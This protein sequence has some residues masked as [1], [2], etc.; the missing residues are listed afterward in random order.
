MKAEGLK[1]HELRTLAVIAAA[2]LVSHF[3]ILVLPPLFPL[4]KERLGVGFVE[5]GLALTIFN[6]VSG[7][8]QAPM[9]FIADRI[10]PRR[11][12][13]AGLCLGSLAFISL[14]MATS[15]PWLL[16]A[17]ALAGLANSVYHPCDYAI[18]SGAIGDARVGRAFS[19]HTF[20]GY[21]GGAIAPV[22]MLA[23]A[24]F[25]GVTGALIAAGV[26]G[27]I[28]AVPVA[29]S[30]GT[31]AVV[32]TPGARPAATKVGLGRIVTPTVLSLMAFFV[33]LSL[34]TGGIN[35]FSVVALTRGYD[36]SLALAN[37]AL[38]AFL[39][40]SAFGVLCGGFLADKT[41]HH[42]LVAAGGFGMTAVL[43]AIVGFVPLGAFLLL[44][45]MVGAGFLSGMIAPSRDMLV[46]AAAPPGAAGRVFG[47]VSTGFN[48]GGA[49]GPML[50][51]WIMD[52]GQPSWVFG[53]AVIF[54]TITVLMA[55]AGESS[56]RPRRFSGAA[57]AGRSSA[58]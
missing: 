10:G 41:R 51:G 34:S 43:I 8:T 50:F 42:G 46:R 12:L 22:T 9:G 1:R 40:S 47:M 17:A 29:L 58:A 3:H 6:I 39:L 53:A 25:A 26:L 56:L 14:G 4:L 19:I 21:L 38:T 54:M 13:A 44:A 32:A 55:L 18:L 5:L 52:R 24:S 15:Y 37:A 36:V 23:I 45:A 30:S 11:I 57:V 27:L 49:I 35:N 16:G 31:T 7:L 33:L 28:V 2:H 48:I 20:A